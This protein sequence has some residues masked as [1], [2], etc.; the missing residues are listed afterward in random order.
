M[1]VI[2]NAQK[3]VVNL[4]LIYL[5][6]VQIANLVLVIIN[7]MIIHNKK[8]V[9]QHV[10]LKGI[11]QKLNIF[12]ILIVIYAMRREYKLMEIV[13]NIVKI[14]QKIIHITVQIINIFVIVHVKKFLPNIN[15]KIIII[16]LKNLIV[17]I[18]FIIM[19]E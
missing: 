19:L 3:K 17:K 2:K 9:N 14:C 1:L 10:I 18:I 12:I 13:L 11:V 5:P 4:T 6:N 16:V 7:I 8:N 15:L